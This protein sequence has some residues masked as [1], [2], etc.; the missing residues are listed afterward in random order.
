MYMAN[1]V[2]CLSTLSFI[3]ERDKELIKGK[4][5]RRI[6]KNEKSADAA[7]HEALHCLFFRFMSGRQRNPYDPLPVSLLPALKREMGTLQR[8][9]VSK[10]NH[11]DIILSNTFSFSAID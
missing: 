5:T 10:C 7:L 4:K 9:A 1:L 2:L 8:K 11:F 6:N 3:A